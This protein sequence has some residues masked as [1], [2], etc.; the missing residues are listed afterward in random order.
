MY[1]GY[2]ESLAKILGA[3]I[4]DEEVRVAADYLGLTPE[5]LVVVVQ[6][7][8]LRILLYSANVRLPAIQCLVKPL[9]RQRE[10]LQQLMVLGGQLLSQ[11]VA[12]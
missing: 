12:S 9:S 10:L 6:E 11:R 1:E 3:R 4:D 7:S 8:P 2:I 5:S